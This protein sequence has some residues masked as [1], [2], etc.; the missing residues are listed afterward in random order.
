MDTTKTL[1]QEK[2][3]LNTL[4]NKGISFE[5][6]DTEFEIRKRFF[7]L[8]KKH[9]PV[10]VKKQFKIEEPTLGT[11]DRLS[12]EW[13][14][15][16]IDESALKSEDGMQRAKTL[17]HGHALRCA[18]VVAIAVIGSEYLI[19]QCGKNG[20]VRYVEDREHLEYLTALF[21]RTIKPSNLYQLCVLINAMCNLGDFLNSIR[22]M[23]SDRS[24][25]PIRIEENNRG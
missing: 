18:R 6:T 21:A 15:F 17:V 1:G 8:L 11:L 7:G 22:L 16:A 2:A 19:P 25:M 3:E 4:I 20:V 10:K 5:V 9:V 23:S 14:E 12:A 13:I 24:T